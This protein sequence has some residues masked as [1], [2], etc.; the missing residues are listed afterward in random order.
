MQGH[1]T[2][3]GPLAEYAYQSPLQIQVG[4]TQIAEFRHPQTGGIEHLQHATVASAAFFVHIRQ[5]QQF[6][7]FL[8]AEHFRQ[9]LG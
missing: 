7:H 5:C 4:H 1:Q 8:A 2:F 3:F 9:M 6:F